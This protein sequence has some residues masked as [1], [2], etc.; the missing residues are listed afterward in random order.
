MFSLVERHAGKIQGILSCYDRVLVRGNLLGLGYADGMTSYLYEQGIR[1]FDYPKFAKGLRE[2]VRDNAYK[3]AKTEGVPLVFANSLKGMRKEKW[4]RK[5]LE[6]RGDTPGMVCILS[7]M[8]SCTKYKPWHDKKSGRT[9]LKHEKGRCLYYYFYMMDERF[10][11]CFMRVPTWCPFELQF[12]F[13]GHSLLETELRRANIGYEKL[14]NAFVSIDDFDQAQALSDK[15]PMLELCKTLKRYARRL[16]PFLAELDLEYRWT[17]MQVEYC[18]DIVFRRQEDLQAI[19]EPLLRTAVHAV[20][21]EDIATFLGRKLH[22]NYRDE[23]GNDLGRRVGGTR[24]KHK[25]GKSSIKMYDKRGI[26]LRIETTCNDISFFKHHRTVFH[27]NGEHST[28]V[29]PM[30]KTLYNLSTELPQLMRA[31]NHRYL[32]FIS[33]LE[34]PSCSARTLEKLADR[35][36]RDGRSFRGFNF[37]LPEDRSLFE[38]LLRGEFNLSGLRNRELRAFLPELST[39]QISHRI[40]RL[41]VHGILKKVARTY[42]YHL[43]KLGRRVLATALQVR[44]F[45][46][47]PALHPPP[48]SESQ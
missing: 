31:C 10:G 6:E 5:H 30:K 36:V 14:D 32:D 27:R 7:A 26:I 41:R 21:A 33:A 45:V 46:V 34:A 25:M 47:V 8:E 23:A 48:A 37:F 2:R 40:K 39:G 12:Y 9:F 4:V 16:L 22:G 19:Y 3:I 35:V 29:A 11:L 43:T 18:T 15:F 44:E 24:I 42:K 13:N 17:V 20:K 1:I 38:V 28:K